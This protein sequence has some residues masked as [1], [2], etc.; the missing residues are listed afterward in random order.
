MKMMPFLGKLTLLFIV[1]FS[2]ISLY[3]LMEN[4]VHVVQI[5]E[6]RFG[7]VVDLLIVNF[8]VRATEFTIAA[9]FSCLA[10]ICFL[11]FLDIPKLLW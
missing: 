3:Y 10:T 7:Y 1:L 5:A 2:V 6:M 11:I 4:R 8:G 9:F